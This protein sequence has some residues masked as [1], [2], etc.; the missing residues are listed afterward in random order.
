V[1]VVRDVTLQKEHLQ[2]L[3]LLRNCIN[4]A[5]DVIVITDSA[6]LNLPGPR[7]VFVNDAYERTTGYTREQAIGQ[8]PRMLQGPKTDPETT[9]RMALAL[10]RWKP[11][12]EEVLNYT[13]DG[14][15]FWNE[16]NIAPLADERGWY[17]HWISIQRDITVRKQSMLDLAAAKATVENAAKT[18]RLL[19][20]ANITIARAESQQQ[21]L[22]DIC[23]LVCDNPHYL[24]AWVGYAQED[25][26]KSIL[27]AAQ[28]GSVVNYANQ[29]KVSWD[30]HSPYGNGL[31]GIAIRTGNTQLV[32]D[33]SNTYEITPWLAKA[34]ESGISSGMV[35]PF[36][37]RSGVRGC[38]AIYADRVNAF[39]AA[40][41]L[42][43]EE[44]TTNVARG[45]DALAERSRRMHAESATI[46]K[47]NFLANMSH[48]IRT[49]LHAING[50]ANLIRRE[51]LTDNQSEKLTKLE[52]A[53]SHLLQLIND[54]LD[55]SKIDADMVT[56]E[57]SPLKVNEI[58]SNV[59]AM[60][61]DRA[62]NNQNELITEMHPLPTNLVGDATRLQQAILNYITNAIKFTKAGRIAI[63]V[64]CT[65][66]SEDGA[67]LC[68]EVRDS[69]IGIEPQALSM[70]FTDFMQADNST[71]RKYGGTGLG[72]SITRRLARLMGGD[73]GATSTPS[74]GSTFWFTAHLKKGRDQPESIELKVESDS[75]SLLRK[76][77]EGM[78]VLVV[79]DEEV[80][81]EIASILLEDAGFEVKHAQD[82]LQAVE[83][84]KQTVYGAILMDMQ[85]PRMDGLDATRN[86]R[87]LNGYASV[88][89][90]AMTA[91]AFSEDKVRCFAAGMN[92]FITKPFLPHELY[93]KLHRL[94]N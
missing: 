85:M 45:L 29:L 27:I 77:H 6:P 13:K 62:H 17:T 30:D 48:E 34:R 3:T 78:R 82:G 91:N 41:V 5:N 7:I 55:L 94:L 61:I 37:K 24:L 53:G 28:A 79:D 66:E 36:K 84:A 44:L 32:D 73:A 39:A 64:H 4:R 47:S 9:K 19:K 51:S 33:I 65:G 57:E 93:A 67:M 74:Q 26:E 50:M 52:S 72:L 18:L 69:G 63:C 2:E 43:M 83:M 59:V 12:R 58:V 42:M 11:V 88:P 68:F 21:L 38:F 60:V 81:S 70:L 54:I 8:T 49:P 14:R 75:L 92:D 15:E 80:N 35:I 89:I 10:R 1:G 87:L 40:E 16:I 90:V 76:K 25:A 31:A 23:K 46:A 56:L 22:D 86:I 71:T 20:D